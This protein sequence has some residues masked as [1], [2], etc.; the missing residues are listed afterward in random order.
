LHVACFEIGLF[1]LANI[2][3]FELIW[4]LIIVYVSLLFE[5]GNRQKFI[6]IGQQQQRDGRENQ[7]GSGEGD[8]H[9]V[10]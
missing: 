5:V 1:G 10:V 3:G 8:L 4:S 2:V 6:G 9:W 7:G